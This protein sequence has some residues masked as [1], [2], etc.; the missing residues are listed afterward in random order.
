M[1]SWLLWILFIVA[2]VVGFQV[3]RR[4][5]RAEGRQHR[6]GRSDPW[7]GW[8][9]PALFLAVWWLWMPVVAG[10]VWLFVHLVT[11][12]I[13]TWKQGFDLTFKTLLWP[14]ASFTRLTAL[15][16]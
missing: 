13:G 15:F 3:L 5:R 1:P 14:R 11:P 16:W 6:Y 4:L 9:R 7:G 10:I 12:G 2:V 8:A